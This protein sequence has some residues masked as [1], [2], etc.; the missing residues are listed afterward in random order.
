MLRQFW[1]YQKQRI[2][3][4]NNDNISSKTIL[5]IPKKKDKK[6]KQWCTKQ[7]GWWNRVYWKVNQFLLHLV[8]V[9]LLLNDTNIIWNDGKRQN[10]GKKCEYMSNKIN[11]RNSTKNRRAISLHVLTTASFK[12]I[13]IYHNTERETRSEWETRL[14]RKVYKTAYTGHILI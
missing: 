9:V 1:R 3:I 2:K 11:S 6:I 8:P 13:L 4:Q 7:T 5:K 14:S 10:T 12:I